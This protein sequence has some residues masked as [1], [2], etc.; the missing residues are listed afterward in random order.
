MRLNIAIERAKVDVIAQAHQR[1]P[2]G[3]T[4]QAQV[5]LDNAIVRTLE[6][7]IDQDFTGAIAQEFHRTE[8]ACDTK[9]AVDKHEV[10]PRQLRERFPRRFRVTPPLRGAL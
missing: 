2:A 8:R 6:I 7:I 1:H 4:L 10:W 5:A 3:H 9:A